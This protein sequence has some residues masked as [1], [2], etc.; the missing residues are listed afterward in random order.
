ML[1]AERSPPRRL[2]QDQ[3]EEH[4]FEAS[5][6][7]ELLSIAGVATRARRDARELPQDEEGARTGA[8]M[9]LLFGSLRDPCRVF[10]SHALEQTGI[11]T[12]LVM[13]FV[14]LRPS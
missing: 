7:G 14:F 1:Y 6:G 9:V 8:R 13:Y 2:R 5:R 11:S 10:A 12:Y 3:L 4:A